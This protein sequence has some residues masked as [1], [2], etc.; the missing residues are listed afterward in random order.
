MEAVLTLRTADGEDKTRRVFN[1]TPP[2]PQGG[3]TDSA[4]RQCIALGNI[5]TCMESAEMSAYVSYVCVMCVNITICRN[6]KGLK[7]RVR[8]MY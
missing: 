7:S 8:P 4:L 1:K 5:G 6:K 3:E 2:P